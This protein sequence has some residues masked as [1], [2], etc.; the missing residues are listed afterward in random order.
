MLL[1]LSRPAQT[2]LAAQERAPAQEHPEEQ[3][4]TDA[5]PAAAAHRGIELWRCIERRRRVSGAGSGSWWLV[6]AGA[7]RGVDTRNV[8][9]I[10]SSVYRLSVNAKNRVVMED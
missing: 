1:T 5:M 9:K 3:T 8:F 7:S 2:S 4:A 10:Q 6:V